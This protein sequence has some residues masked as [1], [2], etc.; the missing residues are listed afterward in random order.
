MTLL[1]LLTHPDA[2]RKAQA[3]VDAYYASRGSDGDSVIGYSDAKSLVYVQAAIR[4]A[5]RL[6][7][8]PAGLFS[9]QVPEGGDTLHGFRLPAGTEVGQSNYGIGRLPSLWGPDAAVFRPERWLEAGPDQLREMQTAND[10]IF[11]S[12]KYLC[13]GKPI[14]QMEMGKLFVEVRPG[15]KLILPWNG[16]RADLRRGGRKL[17]RRY[18]IAIANPPQPLKMR[19]PVT[20]LTTDFWIRFTRREK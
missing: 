16:K 4:E 3:E 13:L 5:T 18:N 8:P 12:G 20:W 7:P 1:A 6:W 15:P 2:Y 10:L 17:L 9:K 14:A 11:S 19:D